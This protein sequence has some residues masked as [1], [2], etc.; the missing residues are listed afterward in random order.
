[1]P[2]VE[3]ALLDTGEYYIALY[4]E[5]EQADDEFVAALYRLVDSGVKKLILDLRDNP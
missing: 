5:G 3:D 2:F 4:S 1:V